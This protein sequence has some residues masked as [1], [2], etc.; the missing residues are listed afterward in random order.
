MLCADK[1]LSKDVSKE[2]MTQDAANAAR[3]RLHTTTDMGALSEVDMV[4]EAVPVSAPP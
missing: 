1:L 2:R 4:I 3:E